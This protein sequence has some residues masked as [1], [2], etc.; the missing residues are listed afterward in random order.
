MSGSNSKFLSSDVVTEFRGRG[1]EIRVR[2]L[3]V[4]E[5]I[6]GTGKDF[7]LGLYEYFVYGGLPQVVL[8]A[9]EEEKVS[10]LNEMYE[11]TYLRDVI[12]RNHLRNAEGMRELVSVMASGIGASC[13]PK[14]IADT[15]KSAAQVRIS[16]QTIKEYIGHLKDAFLINEALR[17]DVK[18]RKYIGTETKYFFEDMGL[19]N[20]VL[21]FRQ[22][23][24][25][26]IME[27]VIYNELRT[28]GYLVDVGLVEVWER[29]AEGKSVRKNLEVDFVAN[30]GSQRY[31]IQSA[32]AL[33]TSEKVDQEERSLR[34][35][36]DSFKKIV[37]VNDDIMLKRNDAGVV[38]MSI[39]DFLLDEHSLER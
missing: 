19:R 13:N 7:R 9:T 1:Q 37:I 24:E 15:F 32:Y 12:E 38:T 14:R 2:P 34:N 4:E 18:G 17:Y 27:N 26:H 8:L 21:G 31:Y 5:F 30:K 22:V 16:D 10:F 36:G 33:P 29:N 23:E 25:P 6:A 20:V 11:V 39:R 28:R 35:I 3:S